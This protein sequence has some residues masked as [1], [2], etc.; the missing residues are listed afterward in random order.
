M[1][2]LVIKKINGEWKVVQAD[3]NRKTQ[4]K[5]KPG[6]RITWTTEGTE[7]FFQFMTDKLFNNY[8]FNGKNKS[9]I[10]LTVNAKAGRGMYPYAVFCMEDS[11]FAKGDSPPV[12]IIE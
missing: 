6:Q 2:N 9:K 4:V 12:I 8:N 5:A 7:V 1:I 3:D 10:A 11:T